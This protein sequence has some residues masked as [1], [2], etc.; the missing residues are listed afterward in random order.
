VITIR[1]A[2]AYLKAGISAEERERLR[3]K[4]VSREIT[5]RV[6][7]ESRKDF[8]QKRLQAEK[9]S[10]RENESKDFERREKEERT[11]GE[12]AESVEEKISQFCS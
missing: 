12:R 10:S 3:E 1:F 11:R 7:E 9:T 4:S 5:N 6:R 2:R 8:K